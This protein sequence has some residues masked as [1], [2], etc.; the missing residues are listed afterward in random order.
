MNGHL[1]IP[2]TIVQAVNR[3][4]IS[5]LP[6]EGCGF[7]IGKSGEV[8]EFHPAENELHS[9]L[10]YRMNPSDQIKIM[11]DAENR[12]LDIL[13]IVHSHPQGE[14]RPSITDIR[15][16]SWDDMCYIIVSLQRP[17]NPKW[18]GWLLNSAEYEEIPIFT[19]E[20]SGDG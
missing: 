6:E 4:L 18:Q 12:E 17:E 3:Y 5:V 15:E 20:D 19:Q 9:P 7:L 11:L 14:S 8:A 13:A 16:A 2:R 1:E 10:A